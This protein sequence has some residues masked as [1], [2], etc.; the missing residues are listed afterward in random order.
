MPFPECL[1]K[2]FKLHFK[3]NSF[4]EDE[5][6]E[7]VVSVLLDGDEAELVFIDHPSCEISVSLENV[8]L[9]EFGKVCQSKPKL[10]ECA[11]LLLQNPPLHFIIRSW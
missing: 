11:K 2:M 5:Y 1:L 7:K 8:I 4:A 9:I 6:D 10:S 3:K